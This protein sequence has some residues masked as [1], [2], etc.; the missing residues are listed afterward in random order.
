MLYDEVFVFYN[1]KFANRFILSYNNPAVPSGE[2]IL[3]YKPR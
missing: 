3:P 1:S 2:E